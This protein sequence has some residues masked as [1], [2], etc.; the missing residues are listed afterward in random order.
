MESYFE[1][2]WLFGCILGI[3][4]SLRIVGVLKGIIKRASSKEMRKRPKDES[5]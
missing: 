5:I 3:A 4:L 2:G 1:T